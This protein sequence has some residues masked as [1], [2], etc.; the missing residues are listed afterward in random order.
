MAGLFLADVVF[1]AVSWVSG[2]DFL[3]NTGFL[4][5]GAILAVGT[6]FVIEFKQRNER[7]HDVAQII[8]VELADLVAR[9]CFDSEAPWSKYWRGDIPARKFNV[10]SLRKF[11]PIEPKIYPAIAPQ[12]A[13][14]KRDAALAVI[15]FHYRLTALR[16]EIQNITDDANDPNTRMEE[17]SSG[18]LRLVGTRFRQTLAP[19]LSALVALSPMVPEALR[20]ESEA[21]A[22]YD[23]ARKDA[24]PPG[25]LRERITTLQNADVS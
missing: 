12:L 25:T 16:R 18:S 17:I 15:Q 14:L 7:A 19:G 11:A 20:I 22:H 2:K 4:L 10:I 21:I 1:I 5:L 13:L 23:A 9:C 3:I 6:S 24:I 8:Y